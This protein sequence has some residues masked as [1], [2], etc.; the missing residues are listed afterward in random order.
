VTSLRRSAILRNPS[1]NR[2]TSLYAGRWSSCQIAIDT[3]FPA[4]GIF[5]N[6]GGYSRRHDDHRFSKWGFPFR[7]VLAKNG[8]NLT[9]R[10]SASFGENH[11]L[12][13]FITL[14]RTRQRKVIDKFVNNSPPNSI[15]I[16]SPANRLKGL[17]VKKI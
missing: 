4:S 17:Y 12:W 7:K 16:E 1:S 10:V 9:E 15:T 5:P 2:R 8:N 3:G 13:F 6:L 14:R 11:P